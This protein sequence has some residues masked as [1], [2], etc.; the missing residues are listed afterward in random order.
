MWAP[1]YQGQNQPWGLMRNAGSWASEFM[2][3][4][5][6]GLMFRNLNLKSSSHFKNMSIQ[7]SSN[8]FL[9]WMSTLLCNLFLL[10][11]G[12][13]SGL[14][15]TSR[16][17]SSWWAVIHMMMLHYALHFRRGEN[18]PLWQATWQEWW[19]FLDTKRGPRLTATTKTTISILCL[20]EDEFCQQPKE[21][22]EET[23]SSAEPS[24]QMKPQLMLGLQNTKT[25]K[26][27]WPRNW[28]IINM[29]CFTLLSLW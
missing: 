5:L 13:T 29:H 4:T 2:I 23:L 17:G 8:D 10:S 6:L 25:E 3:Q 20:Q 21:V 27:S 22:L 1:A 28:E 7:V 24:D 11:A 15:L 12:R 18:S 19:Q 14:L 26:D 9:C 16:I